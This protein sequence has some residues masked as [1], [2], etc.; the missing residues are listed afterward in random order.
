MAIGRTDS[1]NRGSFLHFGTLRQRITNFS[2]YGFN[3]V[4]SDVNASKGDDCVGKLRPLLASPPAILAFIEPIRNVAILSSGTALAQII[5]IISMPLLAYLFTPDSFGAMA[6]FMG[7]IFI[8]GSMAGLTYESAIIPQE[9]DQEAKTLFL[10][11]S[12]I[13]FFI[14]T[15]L[16]LVML[17]IYYFY[18]IENIISHWLLLF[19]IPF[20]IFSINIYNSCSNWLIRSGAFKVL[21]AATMIRS[22]AATCIQLLSGLLG[23]TTLGLVVGRVVGQFIATIYIV[24]T[25]SLLSSANWFSS[26]NKL[27]TT[28]YRYHRF[29]VFKAPQQA[30]ALV[31]DQLPAFFLASFFGVHFAGF[32][33]FADRILKLPCTIISDA[34]GKVFFSECTKN[35]HS[36]QSLMAITL[37]TALVLSL[38]AIVPSILIFFYSPLLFSLMGPEWEQAAYFVQ[39]MIIL[40]FFRFSF[41]PLMSVFTILDQQK[42]LLNIDIVAMI[43]RIPTITLAT[44][45]G[46]HHLFIITIC[47]FESSKVSVTML[48]IVWAI[49]N[50]EVSALPVI[51]GD[52]VIV[53]T[54]FKE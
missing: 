41:S 54:E 37:K 25:S 40:V 32:Y 20:G 49:K 39:W 26:F 52:N 51:N 45:F 31:S 4:A 17:F 5:N 44:L 16:F 24:L 33:W 38:C 36:G 19:L 47:L 28:A 13:A 10:L 30:I 12:I 34:A 7:I 48:A 21:S 18:N 1:P 23:L 2:A 50:H 35:Y 3:D 14:S 53:V 27:R 22:I 9:N 11:S 46:D 42:T 15:S 8:A 29:P 6:V 43:I